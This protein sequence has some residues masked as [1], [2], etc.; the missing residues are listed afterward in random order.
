MESKGKWYGSYGYF[1]PETTRE[2]IEKA[3][4]EMALKT[5]IDMGALKIII[6]M[7]P[8]PTIDDEGSVH[9]WLTGAWKIKLPDTLED[10]K[11][12]ENDG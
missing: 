6:N 1:T 9:F 4:K 8:S 5:L 10:E 12:G 3:V 7:E 2:V 11:E